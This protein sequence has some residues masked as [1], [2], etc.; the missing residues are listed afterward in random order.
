MFLL[1]PPRNEIRAV[2]SYTEKRPELRK[3]WTN[4][5]MHWVDVEETGTTTR[6]VSETERKEEVKGAS[7]PVKLRPTD[8]FAECLPTESGPSSQPPPQADVESQARQTLACSQSVCAMG[9]GRTYSILYPKLWNA[10]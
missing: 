5:L 1:H 7:N 10:A 6:G 2:V 9:F 3:K 8:A 4:V